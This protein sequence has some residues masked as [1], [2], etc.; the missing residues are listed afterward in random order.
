MP[1]PEPS[2]EVELKFLLLPGE[3]QAVSRNPLLAGATGTAL[4]SVYYDTPDLDLRK[5]GI[6]LRVRRAHG[7]YVQTVKR[8]G[9][10]SLF[11]RGEWETEI[12]GPE[13]DRAALAGSPAG[14]IPAAREGSGL[15]SL[16]VTEVRRTSRIVREGD[17]LIEISLDHGEIVAGDRRASIDE[18]ELELKGGEARGLFVLARRLVGDTRLRL[19]FESKS[20]RGYRLVAGEAPAAYNAEDVHVTGDMTGAEAF[21]VVM[22]NC[23]AQ[24]C[25]N[26][27]LLRETRNA[28]ALHQ[29]RVGLRRLRAALATFEPILPGGE[30]PRIVAESK[31]MGGELDAARDLDI[32]IA[33]QADAERDDDGT[34][35]GPAML[36][37]RLR[38]ARAASY[39]RALAAIDSMRFA[40]FVLDCAEWVEIGDWRESRDEEVAA[41]RDAR[42][43]VLAAV[44]LDRLNRKLRKDAKHLATLDP[45]ARHH[46]R[47]KA[48]KLRY[49]AEFFAEAFGKHGKGH[50][51][52]FTAAL[53]RLQGALGDLNDLAVS[54]QTLLAAT[55]EEDAASVLH[56]GR[57]EAR[58]L[59][60]AVRACRDWRRAKA[61]WR[62]RHS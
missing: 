8:E 44:A 17:D 40:L 27:N 50:R 56:A 45:S 35:R 26:A 34:D 51:R 28:E 11:D 7:R 62:D 12:G 20:E 57:K 3:G 32:L 25:D 58:L 42:A 18:L 41:L 29:L 24:I 38:V 5:R 4:S 49:A 30:F 31:W 14:D 48:K 43:S 21:A 55:G 16:F 52:K 37:E 6:A 33:D 59:K 46:V 2:T 53:E 22:R 15:R 23:L 61:F 36:D 60:K 54:G 13:P 9:G 19:S 47:I 10:T 39:D 1:P